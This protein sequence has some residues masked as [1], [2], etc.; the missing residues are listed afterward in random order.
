MT[1]KS[2]IR[3]ANFSGSEINPA[4]LRKIL[5]V[6]LFAIGDC[7]NATPALRA[8]KNSLPDTDV[9]VLTGKWSAP[10]FRNNPHIN[11]TIEVDD[12]VLRKPDPL[13]LMRVVSQ[14]RRRKYDAALLLHRDP[15]LGLLLMSMGIPIR[16]GPDIEGDGNWLTHPVEESGVQHEI[17]IFNSLLDPLGIQSGDTRMEIF[18]SDE[19]IK[20][21]D[22]LWEESELGSDS[23]VIGIAPGGASNPGEVMPQRVWKHYAQLTADL[24][25]QG[26]K[27]AYFGGKG[28]LNELNRLPSGDGTASFIGRASLAE[29]AELMR[30][31]RVVICHD[32]GPMHLAAASGVATVSIFAPTDP[33]RKAPIGGQHRYLMADKECA[34][35]YH[36]GQWAR[37]CTQ[38][39]I[40]TVTVGDV[41]RAIEEIISV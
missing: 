32:S 41:L 24:L 6:K 29:S 40:S 10:V 13:K 35:C 5:F 11:R 8:L 23:A 26:K 18:S 38:E 7:L 37:D 14:I 31:C 16:I 20:T 33:L 30:K 36:R 12:T 2:T 15:R 1:L 25:R 3:K 34:P 27:I 21:A 22:R 39:C 4:G 9:D 17:E 28:D 19:E